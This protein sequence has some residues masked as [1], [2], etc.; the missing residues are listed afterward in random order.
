MQA[1]R[2]VTSLTS[3]RLDNQVLPHPTVLVVNDSAD[4]VALFARMLSRAGM[5]VLK[6]YNGVEC[7]EMLR[8]HT[9][10]LILLDEYMPDMHGLAMLE[11][12]AELQPP[13][14][15][16]IIFVTADASAAKREAALRVGARAVL[17]IPLERGGLLIDLVRSV[18]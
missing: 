11:R 13:A 15:P 7:L 9:V 6:A 12:C 1:S 10:D 8:T 5:Q 3:M 4:N 2:I 16:P 18:L 17:V 14:A